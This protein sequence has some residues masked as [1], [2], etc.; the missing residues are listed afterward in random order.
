[1]TTRRAARGVSVVVCCHNSAAIVS[2]T[3]RHLAR[4]EVPSG[5]PWE[6]VV[7]DNASTDATGQVARDAWSRSG[8]HDDFR[9]VTEMEKGLV[10]ARNTGI[11]EASFEH[12]LFCDDD[13]RLAT[14]YVRRVWELFDDHPEVGVVGG[15]GEPAFESGMPDWFG[16]YPQYFATGPQAQG[17][18][19]VTDRKGFV[20]GA[21]FALR[22]STWMRI[23][24]QGFESPLHAY[25]R[26][27]N[28]IE[29]C[30]LMRLAGAR[31]WY[32]EHLRFRHYLP[33]RRLDWTSFLDLVENAHLTGVFMAAYRHVLDAAA[34]GAPYRRPSSLTW[35][36][37]A[38]VSSRR[39][40]WAWA[41][42][43]KHRETPTHPAEVRKRRFRGELKGWA[44]I[45]TEFP[46]LCDRIEHLR[47][48]LQSTSRPSLG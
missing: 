15:R 16:R 9:I 7:V 11:Q 30:Y 43:L 17:S 2:E 27:S 4:Q 44:T 8:G 38:A 34:A 46:V 14:D 10:V 20:Y 33:D 18:G 45:R 31:I 40:M 24:E 19:D 23:L 39:W 3:M 35:L 21:G 37:R 41:A 36:A 42:F 28:D 5:I 13:N 6:V 25:D 22:R 1:M 32:D 12:V 47:Y 29:V 26:G 48:T